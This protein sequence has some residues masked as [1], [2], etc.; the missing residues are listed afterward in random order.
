MTKTCAFIYMHN[1]HNIYIYICMSC[2]LLLVD[3][4][5]LP[6]NASHVTARMHFPA[7]RLRSSDNSAAAATGKC[8]DG[9]LPREVQTPTGN[10]KIA[11]MNKG[12][13]KWKSIA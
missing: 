10:V 5:F 2:V 9:P 13:E 6:S 4:D 8:L 1:M 7:R 3:V 12:D 11:H